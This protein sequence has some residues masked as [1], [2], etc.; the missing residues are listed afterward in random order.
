VP[1]GDSSAAG[2][3]AG[4]DLVT[5]QAALGHSARVTT[6]RYLHPRRASDHAATTT[7]AA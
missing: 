6:G 5:S 3:G 1:T 7:G 2:D 4:R